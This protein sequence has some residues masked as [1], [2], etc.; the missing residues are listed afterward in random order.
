ML[1]HYFKLAPSIDDHDEQVVVVGAACGHG[2]SCD[3]LIDGATRVPF[4]ELIAATSHSTWT[5]HGRSTLC[6]ACRAI[7]ASET[8]N[9]QVRGEVKIERYSFSPFVQKVV[10]GTASRTS[11]EKSIDKSVVMRPQRFMSNA[12]CPGFAFLTKLVIDGR[13]YVENARVDM[14]HVD[15]WAARED[16]PTLDHSKS[17][18]VEVEYTGQVPEHLPHPFKEGETLNMAEGGEYTLILSI[19]GPSAMSGHKP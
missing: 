16:F 12:P 10:L 11:G 9:V 15:R 19:I 1:I 13:D 5:M 17:V 14:F 2:D 7:W 3:S 8:P 6:P 4:G 18:G